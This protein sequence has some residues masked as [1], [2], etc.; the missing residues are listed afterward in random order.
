MAGGFEIRAKLA[1]IV[2][3][4]I[5]GH[6]NTIGAAGHRLMPRTGQVNDRQAAMSQRQIKLTVAVYKLMPFL[7]VRRGTAFQP[8]LH[9]ETFRLVWFVADIEEDGA[10]VVR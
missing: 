5:E 9:P 4:A 7:L 2:D 10:F 1:E 8:L 6:P 3:L